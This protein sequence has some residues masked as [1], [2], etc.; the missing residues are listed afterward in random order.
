MEELIALTQVLKRQKVKQIDVITS[1]K[2]LSPKAKLLYESLLDEKVKTDS[3]AVQL[4]YGSPQITSS[5]R[6]LKAR[7]TNKLIN[8][9]FFIDVQSINKRNY[10]TYLV[11][12]YL[13]LSAIKILDSKGQKK[14][15]MKLAEKSLKISMKYDQTEVVFS[16]SSMLYRH[17]KVFNYSREKAEKY[18]K[19]NKEYSKI[20]HFENL[21]RECYAYFAHF[22]TQNSSYDKNNVD[23]EVIK[24]LNIVSYQLDKIQTFDFHS[25]ARNAIYFKAYLESNHKEMLKIS[26]DA[27][28]FFNT[29]EG[30]NQLGKFSFLQKAGIAYQ[31]LKQYESAILIYNNAYNMNPTVGKMH[32]FNIRSHLFNTHLHLKNYQEAY[33]YILEATTEKKFKKLY[34]S[35]REPWLI[36]EAYTHLLIKMKKIQVD[37][38]AELKLRPF[39]ISRFLNEVE[40]FSK[41]KRGLN[42]AVNIVHILHLFVNK[43]LDELDRR[44]DNLGQYSFRYLRNDDT[45]RSNAFIKMLQKMP[46]SGYHPIKLKRDA[47]KYYQRLINA[48]MIIAENSKEVEIIP[49]EHLWDIVIELLEMRLN[50][51]I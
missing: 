33:N 5:Y 12:S 20:L 18:G 48:P 24:N 39:R 35:F 26:I 42:I 22:I 36:K 10:Q 30:F 43:K 38:D 45:L 27:I 11:K 2:S 17:Y 3:E 47:D 8:T 4:I 51:E 46:A 37:P 6:K 16:L 40:T 9:L 50:R 25:E 31:A 21:A 41:D 34:T 14:A 15:A 29:K 13:L 23:F 49:Y 7:L 44:L 28:S 32:W 19:L 1:E